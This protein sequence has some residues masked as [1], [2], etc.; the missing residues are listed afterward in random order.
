MDAINYIILVARTYTTLCKKCPFSEN[1]RVVYVKC[2]SVPA[3][4]ILCNLKHLK[5]DSIIILKL[6][7]VNCKI[8]CY[9]NNIM[10]LLQHKWSYLENNII[11]KD[12]SMGKC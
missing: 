11:I 6:Y 8:L 3:R 9:N 10:T 4:M 7:V 12:S 2:P 5:S 1:K